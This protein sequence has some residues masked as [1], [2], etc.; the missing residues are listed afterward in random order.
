MQ[1]VDSNGGGN[2][3]SVQVTAGVS[4]SPASDTV[5]PMQSVPLMASGGSGM[6]F[7]WALTV[8]ASGGSVGATTGVYVAGSTPNVD[9]TVQV[10]DSLGNTATAIIAT[11]PAVTIA[12]ASAMVDPGSQ[13]SF[14]ATGGSESGYVWSLKTNASGGMVATTASGVLYTAGTKGGVTDVLGVADS[15]GNTASASIVVGP[16]VTLTPPGA[17]SIRAVP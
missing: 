6:G 4:I 3:A 14:A 7:T 1:V 13:T 15:L 16:S 8:N 10:T 2:S 12:P 11:G 17:T 5:S 9:D